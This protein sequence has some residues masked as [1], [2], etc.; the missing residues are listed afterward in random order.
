MELKDVLKFETFWM[1][2][3]PAEAA[4]AV[5]RDGD[6]VYFRSGA[7]NASIRIGQPV[8]RG[9]IA[10]QVMESGQRVERQVTD[11]LPGE[12]CFGIGYPITG[13]AVVVLLSSAYIMKQKEPVAFLTGKT[14]DTWHP[15]PVEDILYIESQHKKTWFYT[16]EGTYSTA[17]TL[18]QL[19]EL[20]P[21]TFL[22][23]HRSYIVNIRCIREITRDIS[24]GFLLKLKDEALLPV[25]QNYTADVRKRLG[26]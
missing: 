6:Y 12:T 16:E 20:L 13:G 3:M 4:I 22:A 2:W 1:D 26:F 8:E 19:R 15:V 23:V 18:K 9:S 11:F 5:A 7:L 14:E 10:S 21:D 24:S 25:S 17:Y